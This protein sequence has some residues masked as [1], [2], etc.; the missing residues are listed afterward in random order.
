M[1]EPYARAGGSE[2]VEQDGALDLLDRLRD[3]D[4]AWT[5][6]GAVERGPAPEHPGLLRED[7]QS[8]AAAFVPRVE[9]EAVRVH[10]RRRS[11]VL[12]VTP[13]DGARRGARR[14]Q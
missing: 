11:H 6:L 5:G 3:L 2:A 9:D 7:L 10:D 13:E 12:V 8:F 4:A 14:A 1:S